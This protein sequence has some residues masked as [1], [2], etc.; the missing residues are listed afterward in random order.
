MNFI[1]LLIY[2]GSV[3]VSLTHRTNQ[4]NHYTM[5][6][7]LENLCPEIDLPHF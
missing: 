7:G 6:F 5:A 2:Q 4:L 1:A 3:K